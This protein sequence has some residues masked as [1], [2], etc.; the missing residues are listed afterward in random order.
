MDMKLLDKTIYVQL[1]QALDL[2][3]SRLNDK[4]NSLK[5]QFI[6]ECK[7]CEIDDIIE[8]TRNDGSKLIGVAKTF[9]IFND[10]VFVSSI[11][12]A[13]TRKVYFS[14]PYKALTK[15]ENL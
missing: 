8:I 15:L 12:V 4:K 7:P 13:K 3:I 11:F 14:K 1:K 6:K 2:E 5:E 10:E 9:A